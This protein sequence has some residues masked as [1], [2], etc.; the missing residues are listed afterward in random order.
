[1]AVGR[2][3]A[4][5]LLGLVCAAPAWAGG[6]RMLVGV[7]EDAVK[8]PD[9]VSARAQLDLARLAGADTVRPT[10]LW[11]PGELAP[12]AAERRAL[13]NL[14]AAARLT[15]VR[16]AIAVFHPGSR[17]TPLT[18][19]ARAQFAQFTAAVARISTSFRLFIVGNEPNLNR[20]W[21]PQF[22]ADGS[23]AAAPAYLALLAQTYDALKAVSPSIEVAGGALAPRGIDRP[24]TGRDTH[25]PTKFLRDLGVAY[26]ASGRTTPI[27]D[28]LAIHPYGDSNRQAPRDSA[29]PN[30]A[31]V[32]L[33]DYTKLVALLGEAFDGTAQQGSTL[34]ILYAEYGVQTTVPD[35][36]ASIYTGRE[37][38]TTLGVD[39]GTQAAYYRQ[40]IELAFCQPNVR[41]IF[42]LHTSDEAD[43]DRWQ[44]GV[45]YAD[46]SP[47][48]SL[49]ALAGGAV[50]SR[51]GVV[52][53]CA[54]MQLTPTARRL[55]P[56]TLRQTRQAR[57][58]FL[59]DTDI[60]ST[61]TARLE[62]VRD[63]R[64]VL[65]MRGRSIGRTLASFSFPRRPALAPGTYRIT[66]ELTATLN[67]GP[68]GTRTSVPFTIR[69]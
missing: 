2:F 49:P 11:N 56:A 29:H 51:R 33:A 12:A 63:R 18:P 38:A 54:G 13:E 48:S 53:R 3:L 58:R 64:T 36:K 61:V 60:D 7:A 22:N 62:R 50:Q 39:E 42:F 30:S 1:L 65:T 6:P 9:L 37:P 66:V 27:M 24:G 28:L 23:N 40:A 5:V 10:V 55:R 16:V 69:P 47:K 19:E 4:T 21:L 57:I 52:A 25:S 31:T 26:R 41:G 34:P 59:L 68:P 35:R 14:A 44:S 43:L 17:T 45:F 46:G 67:V 15:G 32:G 20:F 8:Q